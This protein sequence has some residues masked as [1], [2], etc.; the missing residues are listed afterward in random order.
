M[1][2]L[3]VSAAAA[4][5]VLGAS[6]AL[7]QAVAPAKIA[8]VDLDRI[9]RECN[10]CRTASATLQQQAQALETRAAQLQTQLQPEQT[11]L[12]GAV[13]ALAGKQ[14]DA[15]LA[16]RIRTFQQNQQNAGQELQ[17][18]QAQLQRNNAYV[19]EQLLTKLNSLYSGVM[20]KRGANVMVEM[21]QALAYDPSL[22]VTTDLLAAV[23]ASLTSLQTT[24]PAPQQPAQ[25]PAATRPQPSGR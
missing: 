19:R 10:A 5:L 17:N 1:T 12:E 25:A 16:T 9:S 23:N 6:P 20:T 24:A 15:A 21:G 7:A 13:K 14:P 4:A 8:V 22:D 2:K 3:L 18:Q 11:Y